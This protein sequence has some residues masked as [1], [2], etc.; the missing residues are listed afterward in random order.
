[1]ASFLHSGSRWRRVL[2]LYLKS[3]IQSLWQCIY[4]SLMH[5]RN[6]KMIKYTLNI[7]LKDI[8]FV[9]TWFSWVPL[10]YIVIQESGGATHS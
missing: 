6:G 4:H 10:T 8:A 5:I 1:M 3:L 2:Y 9:L 7:L